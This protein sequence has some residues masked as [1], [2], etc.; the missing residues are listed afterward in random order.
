MTDESDVRVVVARESD[1]SDNDL[2]LRG[3]PT[4]D[5][6][7]Y[8]VVVP[9]T[10]TLLDPDTGTNLRVL[11]RTA[12]A[13]AADNDGRVRLVGLATVEHEAARETV[14]EVARSDRTGES[15]TIQMVDER[16]SQLARLLDVASEM[17]TQV[18]VTAEVRVVPDLTRGILGTVPNDGQTAV[19]LVRGGGFE[20]GSLFSRGTMDAVLAEADC[21]VFVENLGTGE[22]SHGLYVPDVEEHTVATL[23]ESDVQTIDSVLL[24]VDTGAHSALAAE[25]ARAIA[26]AVDAPVTVLHVL[27]PDATDEVRADAAEL[28]EFATFVLGS[29]V[30]VETDLKEVADRTDAIT[31]EAQRHDFTVIGAPEE[32]S[33]LESLIF[34]SLPEQLTERTDVTLLM[35]RDSDETMRSLYYKWEQAIGGDDSDGQE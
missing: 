14:R 27:D 33:R 7:S 29:D 15:E 12:S 34:E 23:D 8:S 3:R 4:I 22:G 20:N 26:R 19:V 32:Q 11:L 35:A 6:P 10:A 18:P 9:V 17:E 25:A 16:R 30:E 13:L 21:D 24:P 31:R 5:R 28:L 2:H 1:E